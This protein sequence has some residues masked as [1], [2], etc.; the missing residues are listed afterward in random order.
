MRKMGK[1]KVRGMK[2]LF[3][4]ADLKI[5]TETISF[6]CFNSNFPAPLVKKAA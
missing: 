2:C 5:A 3:T 6:V 1:S 4:A